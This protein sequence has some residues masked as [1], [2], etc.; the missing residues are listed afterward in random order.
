[1]EQEQKQERKNIDFLELQVEVVNTGRALS[2]FQT[3]IDCLKAVLFE[4]WQTLDDINKGSD[5]STRK[6]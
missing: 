3:L 6:K 4:D 1:M 2:D 5:N